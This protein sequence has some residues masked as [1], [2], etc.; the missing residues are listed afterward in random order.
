L[1]KSCTV[2]ITSSTNIFHFLLGWPINPHLKHSTASKI[3][4]PKIHIPP[5]KNIVRP[6]TAI[7]DYNSSWSAIGP[8]GNWTFE[9]R[10]PS[11]QAI[12]TAHHELSGFGP[13][14]SLSRMCIAAVYCQIEVAYMWSGPSR[15]WRHKQVTWT[16]PN[17]YDCYSCYNVICCYIVM[18]YSLW[19][20]NWRRED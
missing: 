14:M 15:S 1:S 2:W 16:C 13:S 17:A 19:L 10:T 4:S 12:W 11:Y 20:V 7:P 18:Q 9:N 5:N 6:N 3:Q 8:C